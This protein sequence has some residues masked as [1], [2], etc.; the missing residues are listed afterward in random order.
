[1]TFSVEIGVFGGAENGGEDSISSGGL[2]VNLLVVEQG[3]RGTVSTWKMGGKF[4]TRF[5]HAVVDRCA[6]RLGKMSFE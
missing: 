5:A 3:Q 4:G 6:R 1:M 2:V